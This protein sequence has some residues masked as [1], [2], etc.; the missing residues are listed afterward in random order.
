[1]EI[2]RF[3]GDYRFLSN[4]YIEPDG[5]CVEREYQVAKTLDDASR[6]YI[7]N[8]YDTDDLTIRLKKAKFGEPRKWLRYTTPGEAK[9]RGNGV[10]LRP[11]W[12]KLKIP[13]MLD[14]VRKKFSDHPHLAELLLATGDAELVEGNDWGDVF[15]GVCRK[16]GRN[17]LGKILMQ[18]REELRVQRT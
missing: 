1:M 6:D 11:D 5:S 8:V 3:W 15:W 17:E 10:T 12:E 16:R 9:R 2:G 13:L 18:V 14:L 7:L 4:F